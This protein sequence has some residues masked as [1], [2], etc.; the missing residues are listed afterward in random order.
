MYVR[1]QFIGWPPLSL[2]G[3]ISVGAQG[4]GTPFNPHR[5][6]IPNGVRSIH[7]ITFDADGQI[8]EYMI[9][10]SVGN[11]D[12]PPIF[13][14]D[15]F[16]A[17]H[18]STKFELIQDDDVFN[19]ALVSVGLYGVIYSF[20]FELEDAFFVNEIK[21]VT[22]MEDLKN[23]KFA[24]YIEEALKKEISAWE[25]WVSPYKVELP[26]FEKYRESP[27]VLITVDYFVK[28][29][30]AKPPE[31]INAQNGGGLRG[32]PWETVMGGILQILVTKYIPELAPLV[33]QLFIENLA[34]KDP[35]VLTPMDGAS[36]WSGND[37]ANQTCGTGVPFQNFWDAIEDW[38]DL[39]NEVTKRNKHYVANGGTF[40]RFSVKSRG[41][42]DMYTNCDKRGG[43]MVE[44]STVD[45]SSAAK[46]WNALGSSPGWTD[47]FTATE[48]LLV[49]DKYQGSQHWGLWFC[50]DTDVIGEDG[51]FRGIDK[52][53]MSKFVENY[54]KFNVSKKFCNQFSAKSGLDQMAGFV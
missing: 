18:D 7:L 50:E 1:Y 20:Y 25:L 34:H 30:N 12:N 31:E 10:C 19:C 3:S 51:V 9:E 53:K 22:T 21:Y 16:A 54:K 35:L 49:S 27:P 38:I 28:D 37:I 46:P 44:Q 48:K 52:E 13:D 32:N 26:F 8:K 45:F 6:S 24:Q 17:A 29:P 39:M 36:F 14:A 33:L 2:G 40:V 15:K 5:G 4:W 41:F 23:D 47:I 43:F 11:T 42:L